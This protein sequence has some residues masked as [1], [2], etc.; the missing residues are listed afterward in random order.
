VS[1][2]RAVGQALAARARHAGRQALLR[3]IGGGLCGLCDRVL[4]WGPR[5]LLD[6]PFSCPDCK[7]LIVEWRRW[8]VR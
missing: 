3:L 1:L 5:G 4:F 7:A 6:R 8:P 2:L